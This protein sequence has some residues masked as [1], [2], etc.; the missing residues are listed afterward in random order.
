MAL[1]IASS[2]TRGCWWTNIVVGSIKQ[3]TLSKAIVI[4]LITREFTLVVP[5][6]RGLLAITQTCGLHWSP[7][8]LG[9]ERAIYPSTLPYLHMYIHYIHTH[10]HACMHPYIHTHVGSKWSIEIGKERKK[11][12][13]STHTH[14]HTYR[15]TYITCMHASMHRHIHTYTHIHTYILH[16]YT[17]HTHMHRSS[18]K[19]CKFRQVCMLSNWSA[20]TLL[21][22][23]LCYETP[24]DWYCVSE[25]RGHCVYTYYFFVYLFAIGSVKRFCLNC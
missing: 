8:K 5:S 7:S 12:E 17:M 18:F 10:T 25:S 2:G 3:V 9:W 20:Y 24:I 22:P 1:V 21:P 4:C 14:Y 6:T 16:T 23:K 13:W 11:G 15:R 19:V